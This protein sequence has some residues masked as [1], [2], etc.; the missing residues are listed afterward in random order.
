MITKQTGRARQR[1]PFVE[2]R[3]N[4]KLRERFDTALNLLKPI[5]EQPSHSDTMMYLAMQRLQTSYPDLSASEVEVL[6]LSV[7]RALKRK[8]ESLRVVVPN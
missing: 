8:S 6:M 7:M 4:H 5:L 2:R 3:L 1:A